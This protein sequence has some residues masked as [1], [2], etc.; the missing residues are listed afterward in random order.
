[1]L[2]A[3][4]CQIYQTMFLVGLSLKITKILIEADI[5]EKI[6]TKH[7]IHRE[8][9]EEALLSGKPR[10]FVI[11][12][13]LYFGFTHLYRYI[14]LVFEYDT[15]CAIIKTAYPSSDWQIKRYKKK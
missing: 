13:N 15:A 14:T 6:L 7:G 12:G 11:R 5:Q 3:A 10:F 1:M 9:L 2:V 8:E 4:D